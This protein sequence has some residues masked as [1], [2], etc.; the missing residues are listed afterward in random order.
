M[1]VY[2]NEKEWVFLLN[3]PETTYVIGLA[4][5]SHHYI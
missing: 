1:A 3:T 4:L 5:E 2:F